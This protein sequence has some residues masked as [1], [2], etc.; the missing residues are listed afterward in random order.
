[1]DVARALHDIVSKPY[2]FQRRAPGGDGW[3]DVAVFPD[4]ASA[5][6]IHD[7]ATGGQFEGYLPAGPHYRVVDQRTGEVL[8]AEG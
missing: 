3:S 7:E 2:V 8:T 4:L 1:M 5:L 6:A